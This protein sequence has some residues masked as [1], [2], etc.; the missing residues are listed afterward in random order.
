VLS[1]PW[2]CSYD[3][4]GINFLTKKKPLP[5]TGNGCFMHGICQ[6]QTISQPLP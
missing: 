1:P 3:F 4:L 5:L 2:V 6:T